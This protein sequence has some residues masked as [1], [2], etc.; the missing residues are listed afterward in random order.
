VTAT[1]DSRTE[2]LGPEHATELS[3]PEFDV[4]VTRSIALFRRPCVEAVHSDPGPVRSRLID[5]QRAGA[6]QSY[7]ADNREVT[8]GAAADTDVEPPA[9]AHG[10]V[11]APSSEAGGRS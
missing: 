7:I 1:D 3:T 8:V 11:G 9:L 10:C 2:H 6:V 5:H 4:I